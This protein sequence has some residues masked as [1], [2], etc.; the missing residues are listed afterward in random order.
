MKKRFLFLSFAISLVFTIGVSF[1]LLLEVPYNE[2]RFLQGIILLFGGTTVLSSKEIQQQWLEIVKRLNS[3]KFPAITIL[4][5]IF[6]VGILSSFLANHLTSA[7]LQVSHYFLLFNFAVL[8]TVCYQ[9]NSKFFEIGF[10]S[11]TGTMAGI[12]LINVAISYGYVYF[13]PDFPLWPSTDFIRIKFKDIGFMHP[14]PFSNFVNI[15][16]LNHLQTWTLPLL[17]LLVV[18]IPKRQW[19]FSKIAFIV[20]CGWWMLA[21]ASDARGTLIASGVAFV[22]VLY[23]YRKKITKWLRI[24][25]LSAAVGLAAYG[26]FFELLPSFI[27]TEA[28]RTAFSR[29]TPGKRFDLWENAVNKIVENPV[30]GI[31]PMHFSEWGGAFIQPPHNIYI[32]FIGE[33]GVPA[34]LLLLAVIVN[35]GYFWFIQTKEVMNNAPKNSNKLN[36][37]VALTASLLAAL[38]HG[39]VSG[40]INTSLS[41]IMMVV[42]VGW[43]I[44]ISLPKLKVK[45]TVP[46]DLWRRLGVITLNLLAVGFLTWNYVSEVPNLKENRQRYLQITKE[47]TLAPRYWGQ[48]VIG[49]PEKESLENDHNK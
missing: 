40:I 4:G 44:G 49:V 13:V 28:S 25:S 30:L 6:G 35:G 23:L 14:E 31:G 47:N 46:I 12:Y 2:K 43:L 20:L 41:Q 7:L 3:S 27:N 32:Q 15:R 37:R 34:G 17:S 26:I 9:F 1:T 38:T 18:Y 21:F 24:H 45:K 10:L 5:F 29:Y 36:V 22:I 33:W 11:I 16:F 8:I 19:A 48:G 42:V 39:L